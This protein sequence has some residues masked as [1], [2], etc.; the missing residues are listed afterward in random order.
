MKHWLGVAV[1]VIAY[2]LAAGMLFAGCTEDKPKEPDP[3]SKP[4]PTVAVPSMPAAAQ[5]NTKA[6][7]IAFVKYYIDV[8]NYASNT[9]DVKELQKLSDPGCEGCDTYI[10]LFRST[11]DAGGYYE[12][13]EWSL[14]NIAA[15]RQDST[16]VVFA[17]VH[18]PGGKH[19][20]S[21]NA[22]EVPGKV[23][24]SDLAFVPGNKSGEWT[25]RS[26][27]LEAGSK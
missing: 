13:A 26:L 1:R 3:T 11:Y 18:V 6:G 7:A 22:K 8:F 25:L 5:D 17:T 24:D 10:D 19:K 15:S 4:S 20:T 16:L 21:S 12:D 14:S 9:G 2:V 27:A 23:E